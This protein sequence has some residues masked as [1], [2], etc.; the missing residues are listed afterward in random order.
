MGL[1]HPGWA[2]QGDVGVRP[3]E[4]EG[5]EVADLAGVEI[6]LEREVELVEGL[7]VRQPGEF[8]RVPE[9]AALP[10]ADLFLEGE[11]EEVEVAE[12][13]GLGAGGE[14]RRFPG[15][16]LQ[17]EAFGVPADPVGDQPVRTAGSGLGHAAPPIPP[18]SPA[19]WS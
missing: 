6:G 10:D 3:D 11:V 19:A 1:A 15:E 9:P 5:G 16:M 17:Q 18:E 14:R 12:L 4:P 8:E 2:E 13:G 7:V